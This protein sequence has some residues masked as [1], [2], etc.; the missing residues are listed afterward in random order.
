MSKIVS[1]ALKAVM[2]PVKAAADAVYNHPATVKAR[3]YSDSAHAAP[4]H[5]AWRGGLKDLQAALIPA[6]PDSMQTREEPGAIASPTQALVTEQMKAT[7]QKEME[8]ELG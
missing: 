2:E 6:F 8:Y 4:L 5:A 1:E 7:P 3:E